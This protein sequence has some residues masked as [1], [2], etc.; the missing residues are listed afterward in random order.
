MFPSPSILQHYAEFD[1]RIIVMLEK[2]LNVR[3]FDGFI[4]HLPCH[5][6]FFLPLWAC[7]T[8]LLCFVL[9]PLH[10]YGVGH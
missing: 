1:S 9:L 2:L 10:S 8:Y 6:R 3:S 7:S 4:G 5:K